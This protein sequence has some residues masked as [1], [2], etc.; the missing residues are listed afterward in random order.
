[1]GINVLQ[2]GMLF[3]VAAIA[4]RMCSKDD[5]DQVAV[6]WKIIVVSIA[7]VGI[8]AMFFG[9]LMEIWL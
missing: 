4:M 9:T 8:G 2:T 3:L 7:G 6:W 5:A 1:M